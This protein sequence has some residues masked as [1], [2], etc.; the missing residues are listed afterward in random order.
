MASNGA[1]QHLMSGAVNPTSQTNNAYATNKRKFLN[2]KCAPLAKFV[3]LEFEG[4]LCKAEFIFG[5]LRTSFLQVGVFLAVYLCAGTLCFYFFLEDIKGKKTSPV[6]DALYFSVVTITTVGYGDLSPN[7][8]SAKILVFVFVFTGMTLVGLIMNKVA[9]YLAEKQ[10]MLLVKALN[11]HQKNDPS[12]EETVFNRPIFKCL[13]GM[14]IL[15]VLM[16]IGAIF[17]HVVE[18]L[19]IIDSLFCVCTTVTT[20]GFGA[21]SF[22]TK[23]GRAFGVLWILSS[24]LCLGQFFLYVTEVFMEDRQRALVN[25]IQTQGLANLDLEAVNIDTDGA[26]V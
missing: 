25:R 21:E 26:V 4:K 22:R 9:D 16:I 15:S 24:T 20:L 18:D 19:D 5:K 23:G 7:T 17:L 12:T 6:I 1:I 8:S 3:S 11:K 14:A 10:E 13:L 2:V